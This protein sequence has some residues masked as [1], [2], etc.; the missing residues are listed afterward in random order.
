MD[1]NY[2][3]KSKCGRA[4]LLKGN[5]HYGSKA[6]TTRQVK[7]AYL[8]VVRTAPVDNFVKIIALMIRKAQLNYKKEAAID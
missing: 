3:G 1:D 7:F 2:V 5:I 6:T 4:L 8:L